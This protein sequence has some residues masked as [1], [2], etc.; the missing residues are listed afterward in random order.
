M[1]WNKKKL[2]V[3]GALAVSLVSLVGIQ[4]DENPFV[5]KDIQKASQLGVGRLVSAQ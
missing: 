2:P 4:A 5:I 3:V 1:N